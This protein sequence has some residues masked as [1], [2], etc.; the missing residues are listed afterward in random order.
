MS[1]TDTLAAGTG[2]SQT[3]PGLG[4]PKQAAARALSEAI[5]GTPKDQVQNDGTDDIEVEEP[6]DVL[7]A[8]GNVIE[9]DDTLESEED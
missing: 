4:S 2:G 9:E 8:D 1:N 7:D 3:E 6:G 5:S